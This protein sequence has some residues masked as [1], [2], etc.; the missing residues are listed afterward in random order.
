MYIEN[1][2]NVSSYK[3]TSIPLLINETPSALAINETPSTAAIDES[4]SYINLDEIPTKSINF[5]MKETNQMK[6]KVFSKDFRNCSYM[7]KDI[8]SKLNI[9]IE[10]EDSILREMANLKEKGGKTNYEKTD[11]KGKG[12]END[13]SFKTIR[14][15]KS[16]AEIM[17]NRL[18]ENIFE[19]E[20]DNTTNISKLCCKTCVNFPNY[21]VI[22]II[23]QD[24][25]Y[26]NNTDSRKQPLWFNNMKKSLLKHIKKETHLRNLEDSINKQNGEHNVKANIMKAMRNLSYFAIKSELSFQNF[27][28]LLATVNKCNIELGNINHSQYYIVKYLECL[29]RV[30]IDETVEWLNVQE[31][32][33]VSV[34]LDIGTVWIRN[35]L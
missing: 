31:D 24:T 4:S 14:I 9:I 33:T 2:P 25:T 26:D 17:K 29:N 21:K 27:P 20:T 13:D 30:L 8:D 7:H 5:E 18:V 28:I 34:T 19:I 32:N 16:I 6:Q 15:A 3:E 23:I 10:K 12:I 22:G 35:E 11:P 1:A